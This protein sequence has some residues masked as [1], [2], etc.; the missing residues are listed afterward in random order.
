MENKIVKKE[1]YKVELEIAL[2]KE[3]F[4]GYITKAYNKDKNKYMIQGF[5]RGKAP[6]YLIERVYG[7]GVFYDTAVDM[8]LNAEY[9][10]TID[11]LK[12]DVVDYPHVDL[13]D[14]NEENGVTF[15]IKVDVKPE[16][17]LGEYKGL[18]IQKA[19]V[20]V[21]AKDVEDALNREAEKNSRMISIEDRPVADKDTVIIDYEGS[22]DGVPFDGG[23]AEK[24]ELV[25]GSKSFIPGFEDQIIGHN[26]NDEFDVNVKFPDEYHSEELKGKEAVF[27]VVLHEI[28][29]KEL[30]V[31]DD[32]FIKDISEYDTV[33]QYKEETKKKMLEDR[34]K[35]A[36]DSMRSQALAAACENARV[37]VPNAMIEQATDRIIENMKME[38]QYS[39][40]TLDQ[41]LEYTGMKIEDV[42]SQYK[43][44]ARMMVVRDLVVE[45]VK[46]AENIQVTDEEI[47]E[48]LKKEAEMYKMELEQIKKA[49][50][51]Y[52]KYYTD[53]IADDK[54]VDLIYS[55]A[56]KVK[57]LK[58]RKNVKNEDKEEGEAKKA[59]PKKKAAAKKSSKKAEEN[60]EG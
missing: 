19:E 42:R 2:T 43:E 36:E 1:G 5:R 54:A 33:E 14:M 50:G 59:E 16:V 49:I 23:K 9:P 26:L 58:A 20:E 29:V 38:M 41:Y 32:E 52:K 31:V 7:K 45:A 44:Q 39:G 48:Q 56:K 24:H 18:E 53:K 34:Q 46:N 47:E 60:K 12:L 57:E 37:D 27:K 6:Q 10:K 4:S 15:T 30:P 35:K 22:V 40:Y 21:T 3:E 51:D 8:A 28:K 25:I 13:K 17:E 11:N 55:S